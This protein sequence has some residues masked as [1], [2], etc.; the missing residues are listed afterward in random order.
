MGRERV[1]DAKRDTEMGRKMET[2]IETEIGSGKKMENNMY[3][4]S[5]EERRW[6]K[7]R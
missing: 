6:G 5:E 7:V 3:V 2:G 1:I 4:D